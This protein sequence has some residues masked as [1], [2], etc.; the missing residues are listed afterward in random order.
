MQYYGGFFFGVC[1]ISS[2]FCNSWYIFKY[3]PSLKEDYPTTEK[4]WKLIFGIL[5][6]AIRSV[7]WFVVCIP[8]QIKTWSLLGDPKETAGLPAVLSFLIGNTVLCYLQIL[9]TVP[10]FNGAKEALFPRA[11]SSAQKKQK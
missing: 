3:F 2:L 1:M 7:W 10:I 8:W 9:W 6:M 4:I 11:S 5:F